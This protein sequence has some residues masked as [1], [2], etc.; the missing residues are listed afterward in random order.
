MDF[1]TLKIRYSG[2]EDDV[3]VFSSK[4]NAEAQVYEYFGHIEKPLMKLEDFQ[5]FL[6]RQDIGYFNIE[7]SK[8]KHHLRRLS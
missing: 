2:E 5:R 6:A 4:E 1:Y 3:F 8:V 7:H